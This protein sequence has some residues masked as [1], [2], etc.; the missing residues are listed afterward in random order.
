MTLH[1][2]VAAALTAAVLTT[3]ALKTTAQ[4]PAARQQEGGGFRF[5][6]GVELINV[7]V[8]VSDANGRHVT[9]LRQDDFVLYE[10]GVEQPITHF[11]N[12]R[13]PVSLGLVVDTSGSMDGDKWE[14]ARDALDRFVL[15]LLGQDDEVFLYTFSNFPY[16]VE[17][18][19]ADRS[20]VSRS[21]RRVVPRGGTAMYDALLEAVPLAERGQNR[22]KAI[23][24]ISDGNDT[25]SSATVQDVKRLVRDSELMVYAI[26]ID[27]DA[28]STYRSTPFPTR[29][30]VRLPF[31]FPGTRRRPF[32]FQSLQPPWGGTSRGS[33][34]RTDRVNA[35]ALRELTDDSGGRTEIVRDSQDLDPATAGIANELSQQY[36]L[37][38]PAAAKKDGRWHDIRVE[39]RDRRYTVRAR[40]G[41][42]A[43]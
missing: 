10:D 22:K 7:S 14:H 17:D 31:P 1:T 34:R 26:G 19:T 15:E 38:Y 16:L 2:R 21:M 9:G 4:E 5:R 25:N 41:Y 33:M 28:S 39:V 13:V 40:R 23:V 32:P 8:T 29:P 20:K 43:T 27:G 12:E 42:M 11:S 24:V 6:T 30:P 37:A 35:A 3:A 36:F 18:W